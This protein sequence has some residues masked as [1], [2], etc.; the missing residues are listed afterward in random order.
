M[1][2]GTCFQKS[3]RKLHCGSKSPRGPAGSGVG[4]DSTGVLPGNAQGLWEDAVDGQCERVQRN[5]E[6]THLF[7]FLELTVACLLGQ[8]SLGESLPFISCHLMVVS[9]ALVEVRASTE[10]ESQ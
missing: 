3:L 2:L 6:V 1:I 8:R 10:Q 5:P 4:E 7:R 9:S